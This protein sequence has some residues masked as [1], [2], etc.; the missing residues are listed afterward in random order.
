MKEHIAL[1]INELVGQVARLQDVIKTLQGLHLAPDP[2]TA[3][4]E[5]M[6][7][8]GGEGLRARSKSKSKKGG[9]ASA[10]AGTLASMVLEA[11]KLLDDGWTIEDLH[12]ELKGA[13]VG[14]LKLRWT[15]NGLKKRNLVE[16]V[17][18]RCGHTPAT[19]RL[20]G[21]QPATKR[22]V[23]PGALERVH[24]PGLDDGKEPGAMSDSELR[25][26]LDKARYEKTKALEAGHHNLGRIL[27][28]KAAKYEAML[29][30]RA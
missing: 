2:V 6:A 19:Y 18:A 14:T 16:V 20:A 3:E 24:I 12:G 7:I 17:R 29:A 23:K 28:D 11:A 21:G 4:G 26:A 15:V 10:R 27:G 30:A 13:R 1:T 9:E 22:E 8:K 5:A 25:E